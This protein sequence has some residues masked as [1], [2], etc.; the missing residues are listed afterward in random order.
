MG[1]NPTKAQVNVYC[2]ARKRAALYDDRLNSREK[3]A[4]LLGV[5]PSTLA[6]YELGL[7]KCI[8]ADN[9]V[10][11]SDLYR[12]PELRSHY[13]SSECPIGKM[14]AHPVDMERLESITL[15]VLSSFQKM[16]TAKDK[17][18]D[19]ASDGQIGEDEVEDFQEILKMLDSVSKHAQELKAWA[20]KE[21]GIKRQVEN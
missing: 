2:Q 5:S 15:K 13:C 16:A 17:L 21:L 10:L 1:R 14:D 18:I 8:P 11:M 9:V 6:D 20:E 12:A 19:I 7:T 3:A 4:E